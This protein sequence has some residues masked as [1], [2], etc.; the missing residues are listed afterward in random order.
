[1]ASDRDGEEPQRIRILR[2]DDTSERAEGRQR[3]PAR[4]RDGAARAGRPSEADPRPGAR[5]AMSFPIREGAA[6]PWTADDDLDDDLDDETFEDSVDGD[7][8][9]D[10]LEL[11][12]WSDPPTGQVPQVVV[13]EAGESTGEWAALGEQPR[14]RDQDYQYEEDGEL[15]DIIDESDVASR[16][17]A[18]VFFDDGD[19]FAE[20][21][22]EPADDDGPFVASPSSDRDIGVAAAVGVG[23]L[24]LG[25]V[26]FK[27]GAVATV[28][29]IA[30]VL[31]LAAV[32]FVVTT[33]NAGYDPAKPL[34][35]A[36][37]AGLALAA[38][39]DPTMAYPV[40]LGLAV[41]TG[42]IWYFWV[43]PG[44]GAVMNLGVT[45]LGIVWIGALGSFASL[46]LGFGAIAST[47]TNDGL[48]ILLTSVMI[49][50]V[51]DVAAYFGGRSLGRRPLH[52]A[53]PNK[54]VEGMLAGI[55]GGAL[56]PLIIVLA[57]DISP[58]SDKPLAAFVMCLLC[59][60][61]APFGDLAQ[62][63]VKRDLGMKDMGTLLPGHGGV[64]DRFDSLLFV[65]P[66]AFMVCR[67]MGVSPLG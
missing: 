7:V 61:A 67:L 27:V 30:L 9:D 43:Q 10:E 8:L 60:A 48:G 32:E 22:E 41:M 35:I 51:H 29:L 12:H 5:P 16:P 26:C 65:L 42:L 36:G 37:V 17:A 4:D 58:L 44:E 52:M 66:T 64:L 50:V 33:T 63:A 62:S 25:L 3:P 18:D 39:F 1:M 46:L 55:A 14:W 24:A 21:S 20:W 23:L 19:D 56:V 13:E 53:S 59:A 28:P 45:L 6:T 40:V 57:G 15:S 31:G 54:T 2:D 34:T 38:Y 11:P 47:K 49:S